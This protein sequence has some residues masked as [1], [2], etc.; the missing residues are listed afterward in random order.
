MKE[1]ILFIGIGFY[2]YEIAIK[3]EFESLG[4][5]V[6]YFSEVMP[7]NFKDK[8]YNR[9]KSTKVQKY[10]NNKINSLGAEYKF[11][12][13]IKCEFLSYDNLKSLKLKNPKAKF[14]LYLWDSIKRISNIK[15]K[16]CFFDKI[17]SFDRLD[18]LVEKQLV[19]LPLFYR[20][21]YNLNQSNNFINGVYHL[22]WL[23]S[24]RFD[25]LKKI[26]KQ[27]DD[28][29]I[30]NYFLLYTGFFNYLRTVLLQR[31]YKYRKLLI[32]KPLKVS[33]NINNILKYSISLD[34]THP[35]QTGLTMRTIE[36]LGLRKKFI[37]TNRDIVNYD[38]YNDKNILIID[39]EKPVIDQEFF[40]SDYEPV[41]KNIITK[42][43]INSWVL[44]LLSDH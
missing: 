3:D 34:I 31:Q 37:T 11:V 42:Y 28:N 41:G 35:D 2:D 21:E 44:N 5:E 8:I 15:E 17:F 36:L 23:H 38:F 16:L 19:F 33:E 9:N 18:C 43:S 26:K 10:L 29:N 12:V 22:G 24:D 4:Y 13:V 1:K 39:R 14:I 20:N 30:N 40:N 32:Y 25:L 7:E 6:E 27:L